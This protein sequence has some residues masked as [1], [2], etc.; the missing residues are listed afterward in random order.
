MNDVSLNAVIFLDATILLLELR[1]CYCF[2]LVFN[3][4]LFSITMDD[5]TASTDCS[6]LSLSDL[7]THFDDDS[8]LTLALSASTASSPSPAP[9]ELIAVQTWS[10]ARQP[11]S[12]ERT[13]DAKGHRIWYCKY[14][15]W[16]NYR[17][18]STTNARA[19]LRKIHGITVLEAESIVKRATAERLTSPRIKEKES[20]KSAN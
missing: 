2:S 5:G 8:T 6:H 13:H 7:D 17:A 20:R 18:I 16:S 4:A 14:R 9:A 19:H 11:S 12:A 1:I 15:Q 10:F 3:C